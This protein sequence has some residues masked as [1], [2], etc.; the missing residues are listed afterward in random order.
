[1]GQVLGLT[2]AIHG[3]ELNG[4]PVIHR[5]F[6]ELDVDELGGTLVAI[7]VLNPPG[8]LRHL[9]EFSDGQD[10]N[11]AF[12]GK[13]DG[14]PSMAFV[15]SILQ[16]IVARVDYLIDMHTASFGRVNSFY[17][18]ANMR[19]PVT[20]QMALLQNPQFIVHNSSPAGSLRGMASSN[21]VPAITV[22]IGNPQA[23]HKSFIRMTLEGIENILCH[24]G[25]LPEAVEPPTVLPIICNA[26]YWIWVQ[27]GGV[28]HPS[29][30]RFSHK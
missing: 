25:M 20:R 22:E 7:P 19:D 17:V 16:K 10:L 6:Q 12:P 3:N 15:N 4:I 13:P 11:R 28:S 26:S 5:L 14:A 24:L 29:L 18:R 21:G 1:M 2:S 9:R 30:T 23:F 27:H 8:F